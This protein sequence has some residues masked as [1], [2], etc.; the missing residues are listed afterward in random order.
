M[1][2]Q[3][4]DDGMHIIIEADKKT[5]LHVN[6]MYVL[7]CMMHANKH[8]ILWLEDDKTLAQGNFI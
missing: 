1:I 7:L 6:S 4:H 2:I 5:K 8:A 3:V